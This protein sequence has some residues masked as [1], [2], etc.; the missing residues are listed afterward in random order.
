MADWTDEELDAAVGAYVEMARLDAASK[1]YNKKR[2]F[3][4]LAGRFPRTVKSFEYRMQNIS[5]VLDEQG[6]R[7]IGGL[8]PAAHVGTG[9]KARIAEALKRVET[10]GMQSKLLP[11]AYK[12]KLPAMRDWLINL[13]RADR[14]VA[15]SDVM[16]AFGIDRFSLRHAMDFLG[17]QADNMDEPIITAVIVGK[18]SRRCSPGLEKEF[19]VKDDAA[20]RKRLHEFWREVDPSPTPDPSPEGPLEVRAAKFASVEVRPSQAA[21]RRLVFIKFKGCCAISGCN[22]R[23]ALDAAHLDGRGW[24]KGHNGADDGLLLRKDLHALYD[25][26]L[27]RI[28]TS[29]TVECG[30][31]H[32]ASLHG[33]TL[34]LSI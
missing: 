28:N 21:F 30:V 16:L 17:H 8:K 33:K 23:E 2:Y 1:P 3:E 26:G 4:E 9:V 18:H 31:E 7:W 11:A 10:H 20:E 32:Y 5:A 34:H 22:V 13:A 29:G 25:A 12:A 15:Y 24:R 27:L 6:R 14:A 19:G